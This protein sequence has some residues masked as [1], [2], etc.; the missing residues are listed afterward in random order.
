LIEQE[1]LHSTGLRSQNI[2]E[3]RT[4]KLLAQGLKP[5]RADN[6]IGMLAEVHPPEFAR[7]IKAEALPVA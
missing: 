7:I 4:R 1:L 5:E 2:C 3:V 6:S